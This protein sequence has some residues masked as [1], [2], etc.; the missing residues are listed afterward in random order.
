MPLTY[1]NRPEIHMHTGTCTRAHRHT[2]E[3]K[4][5]RAKLTIGRSEYLKFLVFA[6][7]SEMFFYQHCYVF[8]H[9]LLYLSASQQQTGKASTTSLQRSQHPRLPSSAGDRK[10]NLWT[11]LAT[12]PSSHYSRA[13]TSP[14]LSLT[15][16]LSRQAQSHVSRIQPAS[17]PVA[18]TLLTS[19]QTCISCVPGTGQT[20]PILSP[21]HKAQ[22]SNR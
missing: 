15:H 22:R 18:S 19:T 4:A 3:Y 11:N 8:L 2:L 5:T 16:S 21:T 6:T 12:A 7:F 10:A 17:I 14:A 1:L 9:C 20:P 13:G